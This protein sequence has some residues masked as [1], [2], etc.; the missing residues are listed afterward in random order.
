MRRAATSS[1]RGVAC[2]QYALI[3]DM[4]DQE[5]RAG[6]ADELNKRGHGRCTS[7]RFLWAATPIIWTASARAAQE[8]F[9]KRLRNNG[10]CDVN[11]RY[12]RSDIDGAC[13]Q[14]ASSGCWSEIARDQ[15]R[16]FRSFLRIGYDVSEF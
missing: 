2:R 11:P 12:A 1:R 8:A 15:D 14:L 5:W 10:D 6:A 4:N 3:K 9:V 7:A 16:F 13:G